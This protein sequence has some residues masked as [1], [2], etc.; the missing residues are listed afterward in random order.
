MFNI[1][2]LGMSKRIV[3]FLFQSKV[4]L[5]FLLLNAQYAARKN[6]QLFLACVHVDL[7]MR[8]QPG[9]CLSSLF[10]SS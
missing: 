3:S 8:I 2:Q 9:E 4:T 1:L 5:C 10:K 6:I 7:M